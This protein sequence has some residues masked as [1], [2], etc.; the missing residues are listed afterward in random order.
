MPYF[1]GMILPLQF[2][3]YTVYDVESVKKMFASFPAPR[4]IK[5]HLTYEMVPK[6]RDEGTNPRYI[7]VMRNPKD[8][9]VSLYHLG[10]DMPYFKEPVT[11]DEAFER[12]MQGKG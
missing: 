5:T 10:R 1:E 4:I 8:A 6:G 9:F 7:Y 12:F 2:K 3:H 11:W